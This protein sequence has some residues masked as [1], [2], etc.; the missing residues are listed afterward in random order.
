MT[1]MISK[2]GCK[3]SQKIKRYLCGLGIGMLAGAVIPLTG[4]YL[5]N[6]INIVPHAYAGV[7]ESE[8]AEK[9]QYVIDDAR[10][11]YICALAAMSVYDSDLNHAVRDELT[12]MGW[13]YQHVHFKNRRAD[14][15]FYL[16]TK[17]ENDGSKITILAIPGT[18]KL[19][20]VEVDFRT[21]R[22]IFGGSSIAEF[23][24]YADKKLIEETAAHHIESGDI[25]TVHQGFNDYVQ[26]AFFTPSEEDGRM[27]MDYLMDA[28]KSKDSKLYITGHS[29]GG[30]AATILAARLSSLGAL[31]ERMDVVVFGSPAVGNQ[32]FADFCDGRFRLR[33]ITIDKDPVSTVLQTVANAGS[34]YTQFGERIQ[35]DR[36]KTTI[37]NHHEMA[38]YFD[39]A[40]RNYYGVMSGQV[41]SQIKPSVINSDK[42]SIWSGGN[43]DGKGYRVYIA[44]VELHLHSG[45][46]SDG[47]YMR[48]VV[49]DMLV[50]QLKGSVADIGEVKD[51]SDTCKAAKEM[52]CQYVIFEKITGALQKTTNGTYQLQ[53]D[54]EIYDINGMLVSSQST[55][56]DSS[57]ITP[58]EAVM[59]D[60]ARGNEN[61]QNAVKK[62]V[63][64]R[65]GSIFKQ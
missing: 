29:L 56:M 54:E 10:S 59:Y 50:H 65:L 11:A 52:G 44:P 7:H 38:V 33:R 23:Q 36:N 51:M 3:L 8:N 35:W 37:R 15:N 17:R 48:S 46:Q 21:G 19:K 58:I 27:G 22:V 57:R 60:I 43:R 25:A 39:S 30:A 18:E 53:V 55:G 61:R 12:H 6:N 4:A 20:D 16:I 40:I 31:S 49:Q 1:T 13:Q 45:I 5:G 47:G 41:S 34:V 64:M 63:S 2:C 9:H 26:T 62:E 24:Q 14:T 42:D 28:L 32:K